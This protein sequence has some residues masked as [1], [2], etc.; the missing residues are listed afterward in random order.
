MQVYENI[1]VPIIS[2]YSSYIF[3]IVEADLEYQGL[4]MSYL[5]NY[6]FVDVIMPFGAVFWIP[7]LFLFVLRMKPLY[8]TFFI[9][10]IVLYAIFYPIGILLLTNFDVLYLL[11]NLFQMIAIFMGLTFCIVGAKQSV[12]LR[13]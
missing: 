6:G 7:F 11:F 4:I 2:K 10:H 8:K 3:E 9:Y 13:S 1:F 12:R 5:N